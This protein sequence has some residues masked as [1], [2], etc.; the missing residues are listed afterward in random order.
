MLNGQKGGLMFVFIAMLFDPIVTIP[1]IIVGAMMRW[2]K[3]LG[4]ALIGAVALNVIMGSSH[5]GAQGIEGFVAR[6]L[7]MV[8]AG[9]IGTLIYNRRMKKRARQA[10]LGALPADAG[11]SV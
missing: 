4:V 5:S 1:M 11:A 2:E 3:M 8:I 7:A 10:S 9:L 6:F